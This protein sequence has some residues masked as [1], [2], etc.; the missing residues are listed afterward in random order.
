M[1]CCISDYA[2]NDLLSYFTCFDATFSEGKHVSVLKGNLLHSVYR[3]STL[4]GSQIVV[5]RGASVH[6]ARG[7]AVRIIE[8]WNQG[9]VV[10]FNDE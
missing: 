3:D 4:S 6:F 7:S 5:G 2:V 1:G 8:E 9:L 10:S